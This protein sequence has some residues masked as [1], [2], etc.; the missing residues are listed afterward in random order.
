VADD[1]DEGKRSAKESLNAKGGKVMR[2]KET[3]KGLR[4]KRAEQK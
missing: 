3:R 1:A 2:S 4:E